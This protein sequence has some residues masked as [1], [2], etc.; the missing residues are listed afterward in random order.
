[1]LKSRS[2]SEGRGESLQ[3]FPAKSFVELS[4]LQSQMRRSKSLIVSDRQE[5]G[6]NEIL[7]LT[8]QTHFAKIYRVPLDLRA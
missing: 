2:E 8:T 4:T 6:R 5:S 7:K 3:E 1:M